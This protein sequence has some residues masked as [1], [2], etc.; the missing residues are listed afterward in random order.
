[1][2]VSVLFA[3]VVAEAI[4]M[5]PPVLKSNELPPI[6]PIVKGSALLPEKVMLFILSDAL[7]IVIVSKLLE[8]LKVAVSAFVVPDVEPGKVPAM[9]FQLLSETPVTQLPFVA[10]VFHVAL[11]AGATGSV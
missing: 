10:V 9:L 5:V 3:P 11:V 7:L 8:T 4:E 2:T 1:L 6:L